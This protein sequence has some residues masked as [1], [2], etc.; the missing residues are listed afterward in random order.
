MPHGKGKT[1]KSKSFRT[2]TQLCPCC[3]RV[4]S[5]KFTQTVGA[6]RKDFRFSPMDKLFCRH[7]EKSHNYTRKGA[8]E[9]V[10]SAKV[11]AV[12]YFVSNDITAERQP[13][14]T[15]SAHNIEIINNRSA[16]DDVS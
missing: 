16:R 12:D 6:E 7:L 15:T 9:F 11:E 3:D 10:Y 5:D 14:R 8:C 13:N 1:I 4:F 2:T